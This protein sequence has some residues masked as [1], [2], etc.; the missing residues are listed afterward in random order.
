MILLCS[1]HFGY[2]QMDSLKPVVLSPQ[3]FL[4][5]LCITPYYMMLKSVQ[6]F[7]GKEVGVSVFLSLSSPAILYLTSDYN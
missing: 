6:D 1:V 3:E 4:R 2:I 5:Y 7:K